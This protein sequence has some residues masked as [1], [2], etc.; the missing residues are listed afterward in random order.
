VTER[1]SALRR[2]G[3]KGNDLLG[4]RLHCVEKLF[5]LSVGGPCTRGVAA[6]SHGGSATPGGRGRGQHRKGNAPVLRGGNE[7]FTKSGKKSEFDLDSI[8]KLSTFEKIGGK[9]NFRVAV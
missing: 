6:A 4:E 9:I 7:S 2:T 5:H 1:K 8:L 3:K